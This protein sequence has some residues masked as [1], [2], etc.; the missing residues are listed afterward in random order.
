MKKVFAATAAFTAV[1]CL[2]ACAETPRVDSGSNVWLGSEESSEVV[3]DAVSDADSG[4]QES[5]AKLIFAKQSNVQKNIIELPSFV[6]SGSGI[7]AI[8]TRIDEQLTKGII[9][10]AEPGEM[11]EIKSYP[12]QND[13]YVQVICTYCIYPTYGTSG[14]ITSY[15]YDKSA[16][17][18]VTLED[19]YALTDSSEAELTTAITDSLNKIESDDSVAMER[20]NVEIRAFEVYPDGAVVFFGT[21][22]S[23]PTEPVADE[24]SSF[25]SYNSKT[26]VAC[27]DLYEMFNKKY[28]SSEF[29]SC[30]YAKNTDVSAGGNAIIGVMNSGDTDNFVSYVNILE[31]KLKA[32]GLYSADGK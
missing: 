8:N 32:K 17:K 25:F 26:G 20:K 24:Y 29:G 15:V 16:Q 18:E 11:V 14:E 12:V 10:K 5:N 9:D 6:G 21:Y 1:V 4:N 7:D 27:I 2:T 31:E 13:G 3:T 22:I 19:A 28:I 23:A 30:F